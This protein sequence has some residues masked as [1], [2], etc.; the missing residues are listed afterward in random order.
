MRPSRRAAALSSGAAGLGRG[1]VA[2][3][4]S[5]PAGPGAEAPSLYAVRTEAGSTFTPGPM[6]EETAMRWM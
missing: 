5:G 6:V 3:T 4:A 1:G 2:Q